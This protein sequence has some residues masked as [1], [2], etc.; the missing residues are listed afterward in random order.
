MENNCLPLGNKHVK[1]KRISP[2]H[3]TMS[4]SS[5]AM[6]IAPQEDPIANPNIF[7]DGKN[8]CPKFIK[9]K[10]QQLQEKQ[11][12]LQTIHDFIN[13]E[14]GSQSPHQDIE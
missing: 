3:L 13:K 1:S 5:V 6:G 11:E 2:Q 7:N 4:S 8:R 12:A 14:N 10:L 9:N